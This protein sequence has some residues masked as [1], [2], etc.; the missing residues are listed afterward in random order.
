MK[1]ILRYRS[2]ATAIC[3][4]VALA[5]FFT[6]CINNQ[7]EKT[8]PAAT[9][10]ND[11]AG[12]ASC[13]GCHKAIYDS[14]LQTAHYHTS[15]TATAQSI[16]GS[17]DSLKNIFTYNN[18]G[19]VIMEKH[20]DSFYQ[21]GYINGD[22]KKKQVFNLAIGSGTKG[23]SYASWV[24]NKLAQLPITYFTSAHAWS[25]SPGYPN[26]IAFN[27][28]ITSRCLECHATYAEKIS[29]EEKE[30]EEFDK[31]RMILGVDCERCHGPA[32]KHVQFQTKNPAEKKAQFITD[33]K[34][35]SRQQS[36]DMCA[37]CHGGRLQKTKPS[38]QFRPGHRLADYFLIDT[39]GRDAGSIDVHGNQLG[40]LAA[41]KCFKNSATLTCNSC[42]DPHKNEQADA[43][44]FAQRCNTC[45]GNAG[46]GNVP[47]KIKGTV[48]EAVLNNNCVNCHMP[49]QPSMAISVLLQGENLP[50]PALMHTH[51]IKNYPAETKRILALV[52][53]K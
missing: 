39:A 46:P 44:V 13:A 28:P 16:K 51:L 4:I 11:Y 27:R 29:A 50:T 33:L 41:S 10:F 43:V 25:N 37:L 5:L 6:R 14:H 23:Q 24:G 32:A 21:A 48:S 12:S 19:M 47:C 17:F 20:A 38:F 52:K 49:G 35:F 9:A 36:L 26:K 34:S 22:L 2:S 3:I 7:K 18:G 53:E 42:H 8:T 15:E 45:H 1:A 40:L 31:S 30:P